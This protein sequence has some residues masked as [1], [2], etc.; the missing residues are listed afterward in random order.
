MK[1]FLKIMN[2]CG[3]EK[4]LISCATIEKLRQNRSICSKEKRLSN[5]S[6]KKNFQKGSKLNKKIH[7]LQKIF[8]KQKQISL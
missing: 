7:D 3:S 2:V 8:T 6:Y 4:E 5:V 1:I